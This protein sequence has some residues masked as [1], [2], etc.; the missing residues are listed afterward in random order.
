MEVISLG[1]VNKFTDVGRMLKKKG[2]IVPV[3]KNTRDDMDKTAIWL[4]IH[5]H[6]HNNTNEEG[7]TS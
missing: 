6:I 5:I 7:Y 1:P 3:R 4:L 2:Q